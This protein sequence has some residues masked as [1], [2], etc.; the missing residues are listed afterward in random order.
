MVQNGTNH[1]LRINTHF[2]PSPCTKKII[3]LEGHEN[4]EQTRSAL[5]WEQT[6]WF[7]QFNVQRNSAYM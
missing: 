6:A 3:T 1:D 2:D 5:S 7:Q 4:H